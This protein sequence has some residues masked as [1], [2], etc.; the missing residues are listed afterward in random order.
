MIH[1]LPLNTGVAATGRTPS[2][3]P[4]TRG[5]APAFGALMARELSTQAR[6]TG[7]APS[8]AAASTSA[9]RGP[10]S[11]GVASTIPINTGAAANSAPTVTSGNSETI[12]HTPF[13][14]VKVNPNTTTDL[15]AVFSGVPQPAAQVNAAAPAP[16]EAPTAQSV[17]GEK[18][19]VETPTGTIGGL[20]YGYNPIYFATPSTATAVAAMVGGTVFEQNS[21]APNGPFQQSVPNLM[22][23]L[24]D[25]KVVNPGLIADFYNHGYPQSYIDRMIQAEIRGAES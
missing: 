2:T 19:W 1:R 4:A 20:T 12:I 3:K 15:K 6:T 22:V 14:D 21:M 7:T 8:N 18:P 23:R 17:F 9:Q 10:T 25:G 16:R 24:P 11:G 5:G 13:G